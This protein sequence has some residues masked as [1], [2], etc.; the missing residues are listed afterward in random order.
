[1]VD[2][3]VPI[4]SR[5]NRLAESVTSSAIE[6]MFSSASRHFDKILKQY[7]FGERYLK[8][9]NA[10]SEIFITKR[11]GEKKLT[12]KATELFLEVRRELN[13]IENKL[14]F[15]IENIRSENKS[16]R[17]RPPAMHQII[18]S[19]RRSLLPPVE[20]TNL[21]ALRR[22]SDRINTVR[23]NRGASLLVMKGLDFTPSIFNTADDAIRN[24]NV[25]IGKYRGTMSDMTDITPEDKRLYFKM[26]DELSEYNNGQIKTPEDEAE[27]LRLGKELNIIV[28]RY[29]PEPMSINDLFENDGRLFRQMVNILNDGRAMKQSTH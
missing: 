6:V 10:L 13:T 22:L 16:N 2:V 3:S 28:D 24:G 29:G 27:I 4:G 12:P 19:L 23:S 7:N 26:L 1:M 8:W 17:W 21:E 5:R 25:L 18:R 15:V 14:K 20:T 11:P 9:Q